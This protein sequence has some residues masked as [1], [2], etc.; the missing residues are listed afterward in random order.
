MDLSLWKCS[1]RYRTLK[2][3]GATCARPSNV[4]LEETACVHNVQPLPVVLF[5]TRNPIPRAGIVSPGS[6]CA[7]KNVSDPTTSH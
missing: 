7:S 1:K 4:Y 5:L 3:P 2:Q 6:L